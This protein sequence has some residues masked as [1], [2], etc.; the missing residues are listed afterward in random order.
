M[1][2]RRPEEMV[3]TLAT[4]H[5]AKFPDAVEQATGVRP[6]LPGHLDR[7]LTAPERC[8]HLPND[9]ATVEDFVDSIR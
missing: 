5:P 3:V 4:A 8:V 2:L 7:L 6:A 1:E 9:L